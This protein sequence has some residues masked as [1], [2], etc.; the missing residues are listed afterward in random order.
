[1]IQ[2]ILGKKGSGKTKRLIDLANDSLKSEH[3]V[4][5]FVDDDKRYMYDLRHEIRFVNAGEFA[6]GEHRSADWFYGLLGGMLAVNFDISL[7]FVDAFARLINNTDW[8][9]LGDLF[10]RLEKLSSHH[11][12]DLVLSVSANPEVLPEFITRYAM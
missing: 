8:N 10:D 9:Q 3:G 11:N 7:I 12:C 6:L 5:V 2:V 1:M 4:I